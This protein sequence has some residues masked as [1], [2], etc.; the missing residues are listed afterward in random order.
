MPPKKKDKKEKK[1][2]KKKDGDAGLKEWP[3]EPP[4]NE[5]SKQ[6]YLIQIKDL[7]TRLVRFVK[8]CFFTLIIR[9]G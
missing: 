7:E 1:K 4:L 6:Y 5:S 8:S 2:D 9:I 3:L